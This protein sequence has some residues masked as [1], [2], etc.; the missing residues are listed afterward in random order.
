MDDHRHAV[1]H[2]LG[3]AIGRRSDDGE[4]VQRLGLRLAKAEPRQLRLVSL[5]RRRPSLPKS[6]EA[7]QVAVPHR[8]VNR[9]LATWSRFPLVVAV[10]R[11][12][13]TPP[14]KRL[15]EAW[16]LIDRLRP[17]VGQLGPDR[18]VLGPRRDQPPPHR[19]QPDASRLVNGHERVLRWRKVQPGRDR[20]RI[21]PG[22]HLL[23]DLVPAGTLCHP[24][25]HL[26]LLSF[27]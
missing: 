10:H 26:E 6:S 22:L 4:R 17:R 25:T 11:Q 19:L 16:L 1:V 18:L 12:Q 21:A 5:L 27:V 15:P 3:Q 9:L 8:V 20:R 13:A 14:L 23:F 7:K 2:A 24:T